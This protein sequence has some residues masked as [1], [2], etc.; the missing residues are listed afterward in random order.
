VV[1][2][3]QCGGIWYTGGK[4]GVTWRLSQAIVR[5]PVR[6]QGGCFLNV[7][8]EDKAAIKDIER[9]EAEAQE[10]AGGSGD[11][12][13]EEAVPVSTDVADSDDEPE[14]EPEPKPAPKKKSK[15]KVVK[16]KKD[17]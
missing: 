6:I 1:C 17:A 16:K 9:R 13:D 8:A 5:P 14:P 10:N 11:G 7:G 2:A 12:E 4:F 15:R 3:V